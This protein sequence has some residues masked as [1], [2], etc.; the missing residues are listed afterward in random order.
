M[1]SGPFTISLVFS[2]PDTGSRRYDI[3][4]LPRRSRFRLVSRLG[5]RLL[6]SG[7]YDEMEKKSRL[8][9]GKHLSL[10]TRRVLVKEVQLGPFFLL[11]RRLHFERFFSPLI[12]CFCQSSAFFI[13]DFSHHHCLSYLG[14]IWK[15]ANF[16]E[17]P[18]LVRKDVSR[19][20]VEA[21]GH[22]EQHTGRGGLCRG[23]IG[24]R[25][26]KGR[27]QARSEGVEKLSSRKGA[28]H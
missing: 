28:V 5:S 25:Q 10:R 21:L 18:P 14:A 27:R 20:V 13:F 6:L 15:L 19:M 17:I 1:A 12:L 11:L 2:A 9:L 7:Q 24:A 8:L 4:F 23:A 3:G 22:F 16:Q 26:A